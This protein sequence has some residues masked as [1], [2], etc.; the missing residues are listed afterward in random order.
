MGLVPW[1]LPLA[2]CKSTRRLIVMS[3]HIIAITPLL[4]RR[5]RHHHH[6]CCYLGFLLQYNRG[7][8][9]F[10]LPELCYVSS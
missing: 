2:M 9:I 5:R 3:C 8:A 6:L 10:I 1:R 7:L 4:N